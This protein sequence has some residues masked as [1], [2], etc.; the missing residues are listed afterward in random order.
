MACIAREKKTA[1]CIL[2]AVL[3][4]GVYI[5]PEEGKNGNNEILCLFACSL[6]SPA[7]SCARR[8][9]P[10][11]DAQVLKLHQAFDPVLDISCFLA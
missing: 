6:D 10:L 5:C 7:E 8:H 1:A 2:I 11:A 4:G 3:D 9:F